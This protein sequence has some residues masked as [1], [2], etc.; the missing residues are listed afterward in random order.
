MKK[1]P[2][3]L[4]RLGQNPRFWYISMQAHIFNRGRAIATRITEGKHHKI[5]NG[6]ACSVSKIR[7]LNKDRTKASCMFTSCPVKAS[8]P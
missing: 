1:K 7:L 3:R 2:L 8:C 5:I 4:G 6:V